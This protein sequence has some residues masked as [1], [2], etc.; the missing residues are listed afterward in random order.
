MGAPRS[1]FAQLVRSWMEGGLWLP[2][3]FL[4]S[5]PQQAGEKVIRWA[6][7]HSPI[8]S[9]YRWGFQ[10]FTD[11]CNGLGRLPLLYRIIA[12]FDIPIP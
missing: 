9:C 2:S 8:P 7:L 3:Y 5:Y 1:G 11:K 6:T 4:R 12:V 10:T